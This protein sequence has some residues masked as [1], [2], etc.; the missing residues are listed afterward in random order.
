MFA[1]VTLFSSLF[2]SLLVIVWGL[3]FAT[4]REQDIQCMKQTIEDQKAAK[5]STA[6]STTQQWR[7]GVKKEIWFSQEDRSRLHHRICSETSTLTIVPEGNHLDFI[8]RLENITCWM[9][10][11]LMAPSMTAPSSQQL[12][13]LRAN[14]GF[15]HY[16]SQEFLAQSVD[17]SLYK[18]EG[19]QLPAGLPKVRPFLKG[20]AKDVAFAVSGKTSQFKAEQFKAEFS[21]LEEKQCK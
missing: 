12:R 9:Q 4:V 19:H 13:F 14:E 2:L 3:T 8:E 16:S 18:L 5:S 10:D 17:L 15:Y 20:I 1:K 6:L 21:T 11:K 7:K